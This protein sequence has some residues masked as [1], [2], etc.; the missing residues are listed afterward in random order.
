MM[1]HW[2]GVKWYVEGDI[3]SCCDR[4]DHGLLLQILREQIHDNRLIRLIDDL[5]QAGYVEEWR[6]HKTLSGVPQGGGV[7]PILSNLVLEKLDRYVEDVLI[8]HSTRGDRSK[9]YPPDSKL[10]KEAWQAKKPGD[11]ETA[12]QLNKQAQAIPSRDPNDPTFRRLW[13][14]RYADDGLMGCTG[15]TAEAVEIKH[16]LARFLKE[17]LRL[18]LSEEK[19]LI[20]HARSDT[21][22]FLG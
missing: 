1:H 15:P 16:Q 21:A 12:R 4:I 17:E 7:S 9:T 13:Y 5:L 22:S 19:T 6:Y 14:G 2:R 20:T 10:T 8:P 3:C 11:R 18:D